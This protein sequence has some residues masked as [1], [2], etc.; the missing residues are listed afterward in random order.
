VT[1]DLIAYE[2][3]LIFSS[4]IESVSESAG[5]NVRIITDFGVLLQELRSKLPRVLVLNLDALAGKL[6]SLKE[7]TG[8]TSC[9]V[10]GYYSHLNVKLAEEAKRAGIGRLLSRGAF[11]AQIKELLAEAISGN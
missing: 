10:L 4:K 3:D 11:A 8:E 7:F 2:P 9:I 1:T 5:V 6:Y